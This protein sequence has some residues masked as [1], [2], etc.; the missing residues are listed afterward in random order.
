MKTVE[1]KDASGSLAEYARHVGEETVV[2]TEHG[3]PLAALVPLENSDMESVS[4]SNNSK[5]LAVIERSRARLV[6]EGGISF[7]E[8]KAKL[9]RDT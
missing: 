6:A 9:S 3:K 1:L 7:E 5:F 8:T 4:L 2:V